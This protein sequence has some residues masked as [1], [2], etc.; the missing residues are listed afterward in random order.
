MEFSLNFVL[1]KIGKSFNLQILLYEIFDT[2]QIKYFP[3]FLLIEIKEPGSKFSQNKFSIS[4]EPNRSNLLI[5]VD[6]SLKSIKKIN[7]VDVP[8]KM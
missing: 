2:F 1:L 3:L 4:F 6:F 7:D 5:K 8:I